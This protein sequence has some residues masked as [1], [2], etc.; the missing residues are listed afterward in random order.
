MIFYFSSTGNSKW[1]ARQIADSTGDE[2]ISIPKALKGHCQYELQAGEPLGFV[3]PV[4]GWRVPRIVGE[5]LKKVRLHTAAPSSPYCYCL[6]TA[7]D[8][9]G[10]T[11]ERFRKSLSEIQAD[12]NVQL[13]LVETVVMP[14]SYVG[15]PGMGTDT[16]EKERKKIE[17]AEKKIAAFTERLNRRVRSVGGQPEGWDGLVR[18][19]IPGFFSSVVGGFFVHQLITDKPFHVDPDR[20]VKCG[21]CANVCPVDDIKGGLGSEPVW[22]HNGKCLT[23]FA[24]Y[25]HCPHHAIEF[26]RRTQKKGQYFFG[27]RKLHKD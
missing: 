26:G 23:C 12:F 25:H 6:L 3:F 20:C 9:V 5:F 11:M 14:E 4:H 22:L 10:K 21:I 19:P 17:A 27:R 2:L 7:G 18:G 24:C 15:L 8:S 1:A 16:P 13:S